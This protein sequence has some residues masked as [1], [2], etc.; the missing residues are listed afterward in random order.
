MWH[1]TTQSACMSNPLE[2]LFLD[3]NLQSEPA[4]SMADSPFLSRQCAMPQATPALPC[5]VIIK[6]LLATC[7]CVHQWGTSG[8]PCWTIR[9]LGLGQ[10]RRRVCKP[11]RGGRK[12]R[13][14]GGGGRGVRFLVCPLSTGMQPSRH[15]CVWVVY[16]HLQHWPETF[17][18]LNTFF[19]FML[20]PFF[21]FIFFI[22]TLYWKYSMEEHRAGN[23][24]IFRFLNWATLFLTRHFAH[25]CHFPDQLQWGGYPRLIARDFQRSFST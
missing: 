24:N 15:I 9:E 19:M 7:C 1:Q 2:C 8:C 22:V 17:A 25:P 20:F 3:F 23:R 14:G 13:E 16:V 18:G 12:R 6:R 5:P 11:T 4:G 10:G 21:N